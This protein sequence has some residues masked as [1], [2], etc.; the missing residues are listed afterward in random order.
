MMNLKEFFKEDKIL[1]TGASGFV[2]GNLFEKLKKEGLNVIGTYYNKKLPDLIYCNLTD[3]EEVDDIVKDVN[4][5][6][7]IAAKTYGAWQLKYN[8]ASM[9]KD[10]ITMDANILEAA[11]KYKIKKCLYVSS[12]V[13]YQESFK[14]LEEN[15]LDWN[16]NPYYKYLGVGW[17]KRYIEK[18]CEFY[19]QLG[20]K[21]NIVRPSNIYGT[22]DKYEE[23]KS[24][25]IPAI[26]KRAL[27]RQN[28]F[29]VWGTGNSV[30]DLIYIDDFLRDILKIFI[31]YNKVDAF[32]LC[33]EQL[34]TI[35]EIVNVILDKTNYNIEPVYDITKPD[36]IP[37]KSISRQKFDSILGREDY[38]SLY[39]G[40]E[41]VVKWMKKELKL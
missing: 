27:E 36:S 16:K 37:F 30:K 17:V 39:K 5:I 33:S 4:Y 25:F 22:G 12:S 28:P 15:D 3:Y 21:I 29:I 35:K 20:M 1:V 6:L 7:M 38:T 32:N 10:T 2:G 41:N 40:I 8:P 31:N 19:S 11:Y 34:F 14:Q 24:H 9:V 23:G 26:I 18:L 13:V